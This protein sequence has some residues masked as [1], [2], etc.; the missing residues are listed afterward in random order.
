MPRVETVGPCGIPASVTCPPLLTDA[1]LSQVDCA[2]GALRSCVCGE[3]VTLSQA[4][5]KK[6]T[7]NFEWLR[8]RP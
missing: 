2:E 4:G 7:L 8:K 1:D 5:Y 3:S 6:T